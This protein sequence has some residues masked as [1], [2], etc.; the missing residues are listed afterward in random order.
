MILDYLGNVVAVRLQMGIVDE[1]LELVDRRLVRHFVLQPE[2]LKLLIL[3]YILLDQVGAEILVPKHFCNGYPIRTRSLNRIHPITAQEL[4]RRE[5]LQLEV[6][7]RVQLVDAFAADHPRE[8]V[9]LDNLGRKV[10][11]S[12]TARAVNERPNS[13]S[14]ADT[15]GSSSAARCADPPPSG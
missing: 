1:M 9:V 3:Q 8:S 14:A 11:S 4:L 15:L 10:S 6:V 12:I 7:E 5:A 13:R 2:A